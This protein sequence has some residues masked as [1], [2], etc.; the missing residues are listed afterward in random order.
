M[1]NGVIASLYIISYIKNFNASCPLARECK[2]TKFQH[3][4]IEVIVPI[5]GELVF[6]S[7]A[8]LFG[9]KK[10]FRI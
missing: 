1:V 10:S 3:L 9:K 7:N 6:S 4:S 8:Q 2:N 5:K